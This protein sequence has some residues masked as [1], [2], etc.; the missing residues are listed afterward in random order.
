[1][2]Y[3]SFFIVEGSNEHEDHLAVGHYATNRDTKGIFLTLLALRVNGK[4]L[5]KRKIAKGILY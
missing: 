5:D 1:M 4:K 3:T 2:T